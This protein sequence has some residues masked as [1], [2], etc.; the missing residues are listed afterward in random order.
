[1][2]QSLVT[3]NYQI[4]AQS[5]DV[6]ADS[7]NKLVVPDPIPEKPNAPTRFTVQITLLTSVFLLLGFQGFAANPY[8]QLISEAGQAIVVTT[9]GWDSVD[10]TLRRFERQS[11]IWTQIGQAAPVVIGKNGLGWDPETRAGGF[12]AQEVKREGDGR[13]PAG[14]FRLS[15]EFGFDDSPPDNNM[16]YLPLTAETECVDDA[17]SAFYNEIVDRALIPRPDWK[18]SEKMREVAQ[19]RLGVVVAYNP[20]RVKGAGSCVFMHIWRGVGAGTAGCTAIDQTTIRPIIE[21]LDEKKKP[22]LIQLPDEIY[23]AVRTDWHLP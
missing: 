6:L 13:S 8:R 10:G 12:T 15:S 5:T 16:K 7:E 17:G 2:F 4:P 3:A 22:I 11:G 1:M 20:R 19:Y 23:Q 21:T 14:V 18:S 9:N